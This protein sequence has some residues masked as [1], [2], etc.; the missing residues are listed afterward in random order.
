MA[1]TANTLFIE[2]QPITSPPAGMRPGVLRK[3]NK[4]VL[5]ACMMAF[6]LVIG[7]WQTFK[8][9]QQAQRTR[10]LNSI[11]VPMRAMLLENQSLLAGLRSEDSSETSSDVLEAYL[12]KIRRNGVPAHAQMKRRI[13][14]LVQNNVGV[15]AL[16]NVYVRQAGND[17]VES[18]IDG[19]RSYATALSDRWNSVMEIYMAGGNYAR[20]NFPYPEEIVAAVDREISQQ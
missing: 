10:T 3:K 12:A 5:V 14:R 17:A 20:E 2:V 6:L 15:L 18:Q 9:W 1:A 4:Y 11:L 8:A 13:D 7:S 16:L 19:F